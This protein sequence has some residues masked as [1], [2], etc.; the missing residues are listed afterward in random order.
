[1]G[2]LLKYRLL[3][4]L[5]VA[6]Y[7][8]QHYLHD[9]ECR[10]A[11]LFSVPTQAVSD[12][13]ARVVEALVRAGA[14]HGA[15]T[16]DEIR[17]LLTEPDAPVVERLLTRGYFEPA[18]DEHAAA[19]A[20]ETGAI[21]P[22]DLERETRFFLEQDRLRYF[23][24]PS[25]FHLPERIPDDEVDVAIAGVPLASVPGAIGTRRAPD[26]LRRLTQRL[27]PWFDICDHGLY[28]EV[29]CNGGLPRLL[30]RGIVLKDFGDVGVASRTV[31]DLFD[32][33]ERFVA[34]NLD[35]RRLRPLFVGGDHA[36]TFPIVHAL[37]SRHPGLRLVALD[38]HHDLFYWAGI[39]YNHAAVSSNLLL[40]SQIAGI[41]AFGL[42]TNNDSRTARFRALAEEPTVG[43][44]LN[45]HAIG[46]TRQ[47]LQRDTLVE[48]LQRVPEGAP[49]YLTIDLDVLSPEAIGNAVSTPV[50]DGLSWHE[51]F[52]IVEQAMARLDIVACDVVE[53]N[54]DTAT[55]STG[56]DQLTTL[57][58]LLVEGLAARS[59][60]RS[61]Q[62][63]DY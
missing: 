39:G 48:A 46:P 17:Q 13:I 28:S 25:F 14:A 59:R 4:S 26:S 45:L 5:R 29:G 53:F 6:R 15:R 24:R 62:S 50:A 31:G 11:A 51:L 19:G 57:I 35:H 30:G 32:E 36:V 37:A 44:R 34:E 60:R 49:C 2:P 3:P 38:A 27:V 55:S 63:P 56:R 1:M 12:R 18:E 47:M 9:A 58:L 61:A 43:G 22:L 10:E 8:G 54:P 33:V 52:E 21:P 42:R 41:H 23:T 16:Q 40:F 7:A 20:R